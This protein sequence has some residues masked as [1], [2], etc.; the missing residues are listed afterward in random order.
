MR[1]LAPRMNPTPC[2][3]RTNP[4]RQYFCI[5]RLTPVD[6]FQLEHANLIEFAGRDDLNLLT[7]DNPSS[8]KL[9][10]TTDRWAPR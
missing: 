6:R 4:I 5:T 8:L 7:C 10:L 9:S 3:K 1:S 2:N